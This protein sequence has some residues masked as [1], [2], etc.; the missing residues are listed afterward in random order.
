MAWGVVLALLLP[1]VVIFAAPVGEAEAAPTEIVR[2]ES[3]PLGPI[4]V[5]G[6]S[7]LLGSAIT[8]PT[9]AD[10]LVEEGWG[11]VR[12]RAGEGYSTGY[13]HRNRT[14][15][16]AVA[17]IERWRAEG[18]NPTDIVINLGAN[19]SGSCGTDLQCARNAITYVLDTIG[20]GHRIWWPK[21]TR[22]PFG[23]PRDQQDTWNLALDQIAAERDDVWTW[24]WP[25]V[26][27]DEGFDS[28][29]GVHLSFES[30]RRRSARMA[31][32]ITADLASARQIGA[33]A[34][35]PGAASSPTEYV[36]LPPGR[37]TDTRLTGRPA[38]GG[39]VT[40]DV[41]AAVPAGTVAVAVNLTATG[42]SA[43]GF[44]TAHPCDRP[45]PETSAVNYA[46]GATRAA[47]AV[48]PV[49]ADGRLC[50]VTSA[51]ADVIVDLQGAF[52]APGPSSSRFTPLGVP[53]RMLDT[54]GSGRSTV[55]EV[56]APAGADA[57]AVNLTAV[58]AAAPG[59]L[60]AGPCG[61]TPEVSNVNFGPDEAVAGSAFVP[62]GADRRFCITAST[63]VDVIVDLTGTFSP[64]GELQFL[65]V[66]PTRT[67]DTRVGIGGWSPVQGR[68][69]TIDAP[70]APAGAAAVTGTLTLVDPTREAFST[71]YPC[72]DRPPTSSVNAAARTPMA[73]GTTVGVSAEGRLCVTVSQ[74]AQTLF[75]TTGWWVAPGRV[76][77]LRG[78]A[79][80]GPILAS[81]GTVPVSQKV[82]MVS[83]SVGLGTRGV[84][85]RSFPPGWQ[86]VVDGTP[87]M[88]VEQLEARYVWG[89][90]PGLIGDHAVVAGGY[91]YPYWDPVRF[92]R[93]IDSIV[94]AFLSRGAKHVYWVTL[95]E[96]K[97]QYI[98][99]AAW[100][101]VQPYYWYFPTVNAHLERAVERHPQLTLV[102]WAAVADRPGITYDAIH[103][104][105]AGAELYS[106]I[107][108]DAVETAISRSPAGTELR[109]PIPDAAGTAAVALNLTTTDPRA[110]GF[111]AAY[112]CGGDRPEVSNHNHR[113]AETRAAAAIVAVPQTGPDAGTVCVFT[114][115]DTHVIV[116]IT[117]RFPTGSGVIPLV[118]QRLDDTRASAP[119]GP[120]PA[121]V[122]L[123]VPVLGRAGVPADARAVA[124][125]LTATDAR[126][127]GFASVVPCGSPLPSTSNLNYGTS[128]ATPNLA[129]VAPGD[130]GA[131]CVTASTDTELIIDVFAAFGP[132][133]D[134]E[135]IEPVR[136][137]DTRLTGT[138]LAAGGVVELQIGG[139]GLESVPTGSGAVLLNI[140]AATPTGEGYVTVYPCAAG[141][142]DASNLNMAVGRDVANF[143]LARPDV[144]GRI[145]AFTSSPTHLIVDLAGWADGTVAGVPPSR[146]LDTRL[147]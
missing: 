145:C 25:T 26:L 3:G 102:D 109:I 111:L 133:S 81:P 142:P 121:G 16:T 128:G 60:S 12:M 48:I 95:R 44:L 19:D 82:Y 34:A 24:D 136:A 132:G 126:A 6:D 43:A 11:P 4:T 114:H 53:R 8:S 72:G 104:N 69:Q 1:V 2:R 119:G 103:L 71:A 70:V 94:A 106:S 117:A 67:I 77:S 10:R 58:G 20:P 38:A 40:V 27:Y 14:D 96:V 100:R 65:P 55:L 74:T 123:R 18:W 30:Y 49:S 130:D 88:F 118:P 47:S 66:P 108:R 89:A 32:E 76:N 83:D 29:D 85:G 146:L 5:F 86:A 80:D 79:P 7:V 42:T 68:D 125:N 87:A 64:D 113:R 61:S 147:R 115:T 62:V 73:N 17:W 59:F 57:V 144:N 51:S 33:P 134:L 129:I 122:E 9:L 141:A 78:P 15:I 36:P 92:D 23:W 84:F 110:T 56:Q 63:S 75:D 101:Q 22:F 116:D 137:A 90:A 107:V 135:L 143:V 46:A 91:N 138:A 120:H 105:T 54:R 98:S 31:Q 112:P 99:P 41:S 35:L 50:V 37:V 52:V 45:R 124:V 139:P 28:Y 131:I 93:S 127:P 97:P 140:T 13:F 21:I 39:T